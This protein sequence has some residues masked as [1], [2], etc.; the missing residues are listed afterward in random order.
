MNFED[1]LKTT[2]AKS[3]KLGIKS[4]LTQDEFNME[5]IKHLESMSKIDSKTSGA[6]ISDASSITTSAGKTMV[7]SL[8]FEPSPIEIKVDLNDTSVDVSYDLTELMKSLPIEA[9]I[10]K[11]TV[12]V[13]GRRQV[14]SKSDKNIMTVQIPP[15]EFPV[16]LDISVIGGSNLGDFVIKGTK[17]FNAEDGKSLMYFD[18]N[19]TEAR[20][21]TTQEQFNNKILE[22][23]NFLERISNIK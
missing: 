8:S 12:F 22:K 7:R 19:V 17:I 9:V 13:Q 4:G 10:K 23:I 21:V 5:V 11:T 18:N 3:D 2:K 15:N 14:I 6:T 16:T 20:P 1:I